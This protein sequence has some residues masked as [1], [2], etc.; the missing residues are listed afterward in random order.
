[1]KAAIISLGSESSQMIAKAMKSYFTEVD[2]LELRKIEVN[3]SKKLEVLYD[4]K[5]LG[6]L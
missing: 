5:H 3:L 6:K 4:G 1:M 2:A